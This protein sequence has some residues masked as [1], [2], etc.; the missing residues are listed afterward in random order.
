M[1]LFKLKQLFDERKHFTI[2]AAIQSTIYKNGRNT[3]RGGRKSVA[4]LSEL[5]A[6]DE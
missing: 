1:G 5:A 6:M 4:P 2:D 3:T